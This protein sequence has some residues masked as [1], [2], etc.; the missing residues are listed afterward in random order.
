MKRHFALALL[1]VL[2]MS[3]PAGGSQARSLPEGD[4]VSR[5][6]RHGTALGIPT[7]FLLGSSNGLLFSNETEPDRAIPCPAFG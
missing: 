6:L 1:T 7:A 4:R 5:L 2:L 3:M